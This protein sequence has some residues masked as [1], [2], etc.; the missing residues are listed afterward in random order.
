[1]KN[2]ASIKSSLRADQFLIV[3]YGVA[4]VAGVPLEAPRMMHARSR[5]SIFYIHAS[6][7]LYIRARPRI[8][9]EIMLKIIRG[10]GSGFAANIHRDKSG[11]FQL[12]RSNIESLMKMLPFYAFVWTAFICREA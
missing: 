7:A 6:V 11:F 12:F 10:S 2:S 8:N 4:G 3:V 5:K 1:M 9:R